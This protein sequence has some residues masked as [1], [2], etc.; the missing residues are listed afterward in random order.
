MSDAKDPAP[1]APVM[2]IIGW[3]DLTVDPA[4][5]EGVRDFYASVVGWKHEAVPVGDVE[6]FSM[7]D[8]AG[9]PAAG[10][11]RQVGENSD[12]P[13]Q[14]LMYVLIPDLD[15]SLEAV[16]VGGGEVLVGPKTLGP[17]RFAVIRDPIGAVM[18]LYQPGLG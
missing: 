10:I 15:S 9:N 12:L 8:S 7:L 18:G 13:A 16:R 1:A 17:A 14:W 11:C 2:G 6:D 3:H 5:A 4:Q